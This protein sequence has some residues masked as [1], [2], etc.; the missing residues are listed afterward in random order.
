MFLLGKEDFSQLTSEL[1]GIL[2]IYYGIQ[3]FLTSDT[4]KIGYR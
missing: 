1:F 3:E 2:Y 4:Q